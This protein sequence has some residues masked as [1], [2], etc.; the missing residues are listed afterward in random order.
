M[1]ACTPAQFW[2]MTEGKWLIRLRA[3]IRSNSMSPILF[4]CQLPWLMMGHFP[5]L[6]KFR[7]QYLLDLTLVF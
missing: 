4:C 6:L 5:V 3:I 7:A 2:M 1:T